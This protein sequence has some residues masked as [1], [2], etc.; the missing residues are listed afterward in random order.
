MLVF[1][2]GHLIIGGFVGITG[3][4]SGNSSQSLSVQLMARRIVIPHAFADIMVNSH[5][6][7]CPGRK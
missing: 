3:D 2:K 7:D 5:D 6:L 4:L 1:R